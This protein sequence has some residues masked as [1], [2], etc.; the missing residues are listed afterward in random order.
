MEGLSDL[1]ERD[2]ALF[3]GTLQSVAASMRHMTGGTQAGVTSFLFSKVD[4]CEHYMS[5]SLTFT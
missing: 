5:E 3:V 4:F 1:L 2:K